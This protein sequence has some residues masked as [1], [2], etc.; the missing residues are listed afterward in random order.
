MRKWRT[1][2]HRS[3]AGWNLSLIRARITLKRGS[4]CIIMTMVLKVE[5]PRT[6]NLEQENCIT[7]RCADS[8]SS[9]NTSFTN[10]RSAQVLA[11]V[12]LG[13][14]FTRH[15]MRAISELYVHCFGTAWIQIFETSRSADHWDTHRRR[16]TVTLSNA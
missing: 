10:I 12:V 6:S 7:R 2:L 5:L 14:R 4:R 16:V 11:V 13:L 1:W 3:V 8:T 15:R 9:W